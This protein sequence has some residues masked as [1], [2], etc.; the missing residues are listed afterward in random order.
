MNIQLDREIL[1]TVLGRSQGVVDKRQPMAI[2]TNVLLTAVTGE[3]KIIAT[4]LE[5]SLE[6][7]CPAKV[8]DAGQVAVSAR[9]LFEIVRESSSDK[10]TLKALDNKGLEVSYGRSDFKLLGIDPADH[11]GMPDS[12]AGAKNTEIISL[13]VAELSEMIRKTV[14]AVSTDD[15]R[16]NLAGVYLD[17]TDKGN[18]VRMVATDGHRL[19]VIERKLSSGA[20]GGGVILPRKGVSELAKLL[21]DQDGD[22]T[23]TLTGSEAIATVGDCTI[24]MRLV[25]GTFPDYKQVV[26]KDSPK[27]VTAERDELLQSL[28]RVSILSSERARGVKFTIKSGLV[29]VSANNPDIGE[30]SEELV[31]DYSGDDLEIGFNARYVIDVLGVLPEHARVELCLNDQMSP[32]VV[33]GD[34]RDYRYV[35]MPMRI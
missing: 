15:T 20:I 6:Q 31:A 32:G 21:V 5:V 35:V 9:K 2:L 34:D 10:I 23:I 14:F 25:E 18:G 1:L 29:T 33:R 22:V 3:L 24:S 19:A 30:A 11:P 27:V 26:P 8:K 16:S 13:P 4:D 12:T 7:A 17:K 28:R